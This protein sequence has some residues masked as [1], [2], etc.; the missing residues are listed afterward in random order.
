MEAF[1][2]PARVRPARSHLARASGVLGILC[3]AWLAAAPAHA[4]CGFYVGKADASLFNSASQV[5]IARD[6][7]RTVI[8]MLNDYQGEPREFALV[9][10]VPQVLQRGQVNVGDR[11]IFER[12]DAYSSPRLAEYRDDNPCE[13]RIAL[14][15]ALPAAAAGRATTAETDTRARATGVTVEARYTVGEYDI[16]ILSARESDGLEVWLR[17]NGYRLPAGASA[18]LAPYLKLGMKF[19]VARVNLAEHAR[20]G[21]ALLR[22][23]QFAF[24]SEK[25]MLPLRLG[26]LN[27]NGP[28]D[29]IV[30]ALGR[31][32]RV[33]ATNYRT[34]RLP[35][36]VELPGFVKQ[37]FASFYRAMFD[38]QAQREGLRAVFTEYVWDT[39]WCDPCAADPLTPAE[40]RQAGVFWS[41]TQRTVLTRLHVRYTP[42]TFP[43]D[44]MLQETR[45][46]ANFQTRYVLRQPWTGPA[47]CDAAAA[48]LD[49]VRQRHDRQARTLSDLT[50]WELARVLDRMELKPPFAPQPDSAPW[51]RSLWQQSWSTR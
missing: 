14:Q 10:P 36:N 13:P 30:Y 8:S 3:G 24:E 17:D 32:G 18:A 48:Y 26:M 29:L 1:P 16:A 25:H 49:Q 12:I 23:L 46:R 22:P 31:Q 39:G 37:D 47:E 42:Q 50:G 9:V 27:A 43:E 4:F 15:R 40:L 34:V 41:D 7:P 35:A 44:L 38:R 28:Q 45:D 11:R 21:S 6:G 51:W 20:S 19:F 2:C 5:I 33:E